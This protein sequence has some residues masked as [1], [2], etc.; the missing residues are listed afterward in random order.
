MFEN[1]AMKL[2]VYNMQEDYPDSR[3]ANKFYQGLP[4]SITMFWMNRVT[5]IL[6]M[7]VPI[8]QIQLNATVHDSHNL[9]DASVSLIIWDAYLFGATFVMLSLALVMICLHIPCFF[10]HKQSRSDTKIQPF[11][12]P[13]NIQDSCSLLMP[14]R[15][16]TSDTCVLPPI[17]TFI[18]QEGIHACPSISD[19]CIRACASIN[20][21]ASY[22]EHRM[23]M[24]D[25]GC[26]ETVF[27]HD[28]EM[29]QKCIDFNPGADTVGSG[30]SSEFRTD[31]SA[32]A[33]LALLYTDL[34]G[35]EQYQYITPNNIWRT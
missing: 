10:Y 12:H 26:N 2:R 1:K 11:K 14:S 16:P 17:T 9:S 33:T 18:N 28:Q 34:M 35:K 5:A 4:A 30:V 8:P 24:I 19:D 15:L 25:S 27:K 31:G 22:P 6:A 13:W 23:G 32:T 3:L 7:S 21:E 29:R 20:L